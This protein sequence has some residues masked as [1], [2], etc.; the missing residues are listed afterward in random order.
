MAGTAAVTLPEPGSV[1]GLDLAAMSEDELSALHT[2]LCSDHRDRYRELEAKIQTWLPSWRDKRAAWERRAADITA[3]H[4]ALRA[5]W[6][7]NGQ[8]S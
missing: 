6:H 1:A 4:G 5:L 8:Q 7:V 3:V 2:A